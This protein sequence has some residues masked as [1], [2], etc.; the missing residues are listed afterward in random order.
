MMS[1]MARM[2]FCMS[3]ALPL[4]SCSGGGSNEPTGSTPAATATASAQ[5]Q[6]DANP[7]TD[8]A[9]YKIYQG[10]ASGQYGAP[11][12]TVPA[13]STSYEADGLQKGSTYFFVVT[14]YDTSGNEGPLSAELT[15]PIP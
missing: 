12:A 2:I 9:G 7:E 3:L 13:S 14:A 15:I 11:I 1:T 4:V 6:W 10:T 5:F 8:L